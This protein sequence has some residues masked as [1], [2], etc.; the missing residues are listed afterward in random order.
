LNPM[1]GKREV[2]NVTANCMLVTTNTLPRGTLNGISPFVPSGKSSTKL[3]LP[4][5]Q[6][7]SKTDSNVTISLA[8][9]GSRAEAALTITVRLRKTRVTTDHRIAENGVF[10]TFF[11]SHL[12]IYNKNALT[13]PCFS[14]EGV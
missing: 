3:S 2:G 9:L 7:S 8:F 1:L 14:R 13:R 12:L 11:T 10:F 4:P 6:V 5:V